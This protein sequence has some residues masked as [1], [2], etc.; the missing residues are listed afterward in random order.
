MYEVADKYF[1]ISIKYNINGQCH[2]QNLTPLDAT[3]LLRANQN[4]SFF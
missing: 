2:I 3:H 4:K 1:N